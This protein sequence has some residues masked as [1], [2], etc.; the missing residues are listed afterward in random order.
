MV[1]D[2][3]SK[4]EHRVYALEQH[5][6]SMSEWRKSVEENT[7]VQ[8]EVVAVGKDIIAAIRVLGWIGT[9]IKWLASISAACAVVLAAFKGWF[10][11]GQ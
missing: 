9:G 5:A 1:D 11:I 3:F 8:K 2:K 6:D 7:E 10:H 4:L